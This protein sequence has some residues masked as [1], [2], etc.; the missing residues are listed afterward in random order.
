MIIKPLF[1]SRS[2]EKST[3]FNSKHRKVN[4]NKKLKNTLE[5][6]KDKIKIND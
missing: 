4:R 1:W 2:P 6:S 3:V 5:E